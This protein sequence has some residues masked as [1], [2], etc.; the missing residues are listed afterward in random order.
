M[1]RKFYAGCCV[2]LFSFI[3]TAA[4]AALLPLSFTVN[5]AVRDMALGQTQVLQYTITNNVKSLS[6]PIKSIGFVNQGDSQPAD[7]TSYTSSCSDTLAPQQSCT[8]TVTIQNLIQGVLKRNLT[9][10]YGGRAPLQTPLNIAVNQAKYTI[11]IYMVGTD[12]ESVSHSATENIEQMETIGSTANMNVVLETG[13]ALSPGWTTVQRRLVQ[14]GGFYLVEDLGALNMANAST[15]EDFLQWGMTNYP[16]DKYLLVFWDHGGG[17]NGGYGGDEIFSH[18]T[19]PINQLSLA[20]ANAVAQTGKP[21]ELIGFDTCLL[22][23][24]ETISGL[25]PYTHYYVGSEDVEPGAGWQ[26]NTFMNYINQNPTATGLTIGKEIIDGYTQQNSGDETT[27]S[28][29]D[30]T[31]VPALLTAINNFSL[32]AE[33][34]TNTVADWKALARA[35]LAAPDFY[36][37]IWKTRSA[38]VVDLISLVNQVKA[39]FPSDNN[40]QTTSTALLN[41]SNNAI[42][43]LQNSATRQDSLGLTIYYPSV[44]A[45]YA[46]NYPNVTILNGVNFFAEN[47]STFISS[48]MDFYNAQISSLVAVPSSL[49]F[50]GT[51]YTAQISNDFDEVFAAVGND[52]CTNVTGF[53]TIPCYVAIQYS[54]IEQSF[55]SGNSTWS[56]SFNKNDNL[57]S[58]PMINGQP[59]LLIPEDSKIVE[60]EVDSFIVPVFWV[61][62]EEDGFLA[63][64]FQNGKYVVTG[65]QKFVGSSNTQSKVT[66]IPDG[67]IFNLKAYAFSGIWSLLPTSVTV[68]S[69]L[70]IT[71]GAIDDSSNDAFRYLVGDLTGALNIT[72]SS[73]AY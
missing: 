36:T 41:A 52:A 23:N 20:V 63:V 27:L 66:D 49:A 11:L 32:A 47:Y 68:T 34:H 48:Y 15:I 53:G 57:N 21:F 29:I 17:P 35:R 14:Q 61:N 71:F 10:E 33:A 2:I 65:F 45:G 38:D 12:L 69:P 19:T 6:L 54:P 70:Q 60:P 50:D 39:A 43:Y 55:N 64:T 40:V 73:V 24:A 30:A 56:V 51:N 31:Q 18:A 9:I 46:T 4:F 5:P 8:I 44:L 28:L 67:A 7:A 42:K 22:G 37:S 13:G 16:A 1:L 3:N 59:M 72:S 26:Y 62:G 58:W 25:Y